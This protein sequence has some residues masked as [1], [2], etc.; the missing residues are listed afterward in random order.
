VARLQARPE[1][2]TLRL[3]TVPIIGYLFSVRVAAGE[4]ILGST[5]LAHPGSREVGRITAGPGY[6]TGGLQSV[7]WVEAVDCVGEG[8]APLSRELRTT[9]RQAW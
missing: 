4:P 5:S 8:A 9:A 1:S 6:W 3:R 7:A 2:S